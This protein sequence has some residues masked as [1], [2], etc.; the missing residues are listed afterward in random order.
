MPS[1]PSLPNGTTISTSLALFT[2]TSS[3]TFA[4][5][6]R[7]SSR[8]FASETGLRK[9]LCRKSILSSCT[10]CTK[11]GCWTSVRTKWWRLMA[12]SLWKRLRR[13]SWARGEVFLRKVGSWL[14]WTSN[15]ASAE[16]SWS[17]LIN[18]WCVKNVCYFCIDTWAS[19]LFCCVFWA[20]LAGSSG[21]MLLQLEPSLSFW[22]FLFFHWMTLLKTNR[23]N[24]AVIFDRCKCIKDRWLFLYEKL[25]SRILD[26]FLWVMTNA[27]KPFVKIHLSWFQNINVSSDYNLI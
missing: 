15:V 5:L 9:G 8:G 6:L 27:V 24:S 17:C 16:I 23:L 1:T 26:W 7:L 10:N 22:S 20:Y 25:H 3:C 2:L 19:R 11:I 18:F 14:T 4:P 21:L 13:S 12:T